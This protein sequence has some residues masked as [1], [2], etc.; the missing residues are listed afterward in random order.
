MKDI[1]NYWEYFIEWI[2]RLNWGTVP[3]WF[4]ALGTIAAVFVAVYLPYRA[5]RPRGKAELESM[6]YTPQVE[7]MG[8]KVSFYNTGSTAINIRSLSIGL[9]G[10]TKMLLLSMEFLGGVIQPGEGYS[11]GCNAVG[12]YKTLKDIYGPNKKVKIYPKVTDSI[13][14]IYTGK[15]IS[16]SLKSMREDLKFQYQYYNLNPQAA[17]A[18]NEELFNTKKID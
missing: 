7:L 12:V 3:D 13:G 2:K 4:G 18:E 10:S 15:V 17:N 14:N 16:L 5:T 1:G 11:T 6:Y 8:F 9:V